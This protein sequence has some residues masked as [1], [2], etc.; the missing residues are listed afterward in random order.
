VM[1]RSTPSNWEIKLEN[2]TTIWLI[3]SPDRIATEPRMKLVRL[4]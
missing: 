1:S 3:P 4:E 2:P